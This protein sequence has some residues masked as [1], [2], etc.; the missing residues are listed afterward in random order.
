MPIRINLLAEAQATEELRRKD[1]V[2]RGIWVAGFF[3]SLVLLWTLK[4]QCD[5]W[6]EQK[7]LN[8]INASWAEKKANYA[9]V[10][11]NVFKTATIDKKLEALDDLST[12]RFLWAPVLNALQKSVVNDVQV[13]HFKGEQRYITEISGSGAAKKAGGEVEKISLFIDAKDC[14][15]TQQNYT[16]FKE[17]LGSSDYFVKSL[18]RHDGFVIEG[19]LSLPTADPSDPSRSY[20]TFALSSHYPEVRR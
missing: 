17:A 11:N 15:A 5:I 14:N 7:D 9:A 13:T 8:R 1:P 19:T 10:T 2:K 20:V 16:K 4:L 6:F 3:I 18:G 12:N